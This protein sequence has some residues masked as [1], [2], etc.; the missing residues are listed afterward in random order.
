MS[1]GE[2]V[3]DTVD[4]YF[5]RATKYH[6]SDP[7]CDPWTKNGQTSTQLRL[8][9]DDRIVTDPNKIGNVA[10]D[11]RFVPEGSLVYE[12][13]TE[14]FFVSTTGGTAVIDRRS[15]RAIAQMRDLSEKYSRA[16]V[17]DFYFPQE[18]VDEH[19]TK[20]LVVEHD[21]KPFRRLD[22]ESQQR[23][24]DPEFWIERLET[25]RKEADKE[26]KQRFDVMLKRLR[27]IEGS[28]LD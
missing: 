20:C 2:M 5:V 11:P 10:V 19:Y 8:P 15:A 23:R 26:S 7:K 17:F 9:K 27:E 3:G 16:L 28:S 22:R 13:Q 6:R 14:R 18:V 25:L 1:T 24:L 21:G 12:T 4:T